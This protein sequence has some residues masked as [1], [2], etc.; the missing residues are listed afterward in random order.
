MLIHHDPDE[1]ET[2]TTSH[3]CPFHERHPGEA[4]AGC[5]CSASVSQH[6]RDPADVAKIKARKRRE[7]E[8]RILAE[9]EA[10]RARRAV[11]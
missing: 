3:M 10:I 4:F 9:A 7:H 6:R 2:V 1:W 8:D 5:T 11:Q